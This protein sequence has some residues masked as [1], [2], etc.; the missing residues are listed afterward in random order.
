M[1]ASEYPQTSPRR[2]VSTPITL[3]LAIPD[4]LKTAVAPNGVVLCIAHR[5][6]NRGFLLP[7]ELLEVVSA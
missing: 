6:A 2:W 3:S 4:R 7:C 5:L 1:L